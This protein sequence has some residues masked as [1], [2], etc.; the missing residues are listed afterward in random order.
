MRGT[1][2]W[3]EGGLGLGWDGQLELHK[4]RHRVVA[5]GGSSIG[6]SS[7]RGKE[8]KGSCGAARLEAT[9]QPQCHPQRMRLEGVE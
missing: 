4:V 3:A 2:G 6:G 1:L 8:R 7:T 9:V 5:Q